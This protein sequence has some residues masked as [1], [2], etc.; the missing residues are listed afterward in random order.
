[1]NL[2]TVSNGFVIEDYFYYKNKS[3]SWN[4]LHNMNIN[5]VSFT[6]GDKEGLNVDE[7]Y[8]VEEKLPYLVVVIDGFLHLS[9]IGELNSIHVFQPGSKITGVKTDD[10]SYVFLALRITD[11]YGNMEGYVISFLI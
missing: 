3:K 10:G 5:H 6:V 4:V 7:M 1:M 11:Q 8:L 2:G 9:K